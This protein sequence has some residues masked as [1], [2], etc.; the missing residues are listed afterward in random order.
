MEGIPKIFMMLL[1]GEGKI[2]VKS[3]RRLHEVRG[4]MGVAEYAC[5][6]YN[7]TILF[8]IPYF[9]LTK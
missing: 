2:E 7:L 5:S 4:V 6:S 1:F 9:L 8:S 3:Q